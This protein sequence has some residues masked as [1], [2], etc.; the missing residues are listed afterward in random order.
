[1]TCWIYVVKNEGWDI[2][3]K[4]YKNG[5]CITPT[6]SFCEKI[7]DG[8]TVL[9]YQKHI[10][11]NLKH[12]FMACCK[13]GDKMMLND[14]NMDVFSDRNTNKYYVKLSNMRLYDDIIKPSALDIKADQLKKHMKNFHT[15]TELPHELGQNLEQSLS[16][17]DHEIINFATCDENSDN[18][19]IRKNSKIKKD[20]F[21]DS[22]SDT[23]TDKSIRKNTDSDTDTDTESETD[24]DCQGNIPVLM[25]P[26]NKFKW[27]KDN[28][29][30]IIEHYM[31]CAMCDKTDNN[32]IKFVFD[33]KK[34]VYKEIDDED[35][36][37]TLLEIYYKLEGCNKK[38]NDEI[39]VYKIDNDEHEYYESILI[40]F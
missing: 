23:D 27:K 40:L 2:L 16:S 6:F 20:L 18:T 29:Q 5:S 15:F 7:K 37:N 24:D 26:C 9:I 21:S 1:M 25:I 28:K 12:G 39:H 11:S 22:E 19:S 4:S 17:F 14:G 8:D 30:D 36:I 3:K 10:S 33:K 13:V 34:I 38:L 32:N 35:E 31:T